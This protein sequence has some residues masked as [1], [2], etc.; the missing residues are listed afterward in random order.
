MFTLVC[1][2]M[3]WW[4][5]A[6]KNHSHVIKTADNVTFFTS[7]FSDIFKIHLQNTFSI[8]ICHHHDIVVLVS[9]TGLLLNQHHA[10]T[11]TNADIIDETCKKHPNDKFEHTEEF[12]HQVQLKL[13]VTSVIPLCFRCVLCCPGLPSLL[14]CL[15]M[16]YWPPRCNAFLT[17]ASCL[18]FSPNSRCLFS[19]RD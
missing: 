8:W 9:C 3:V 17:P 7:D 12:S 16:L 5:Y 2:I 10:I 14:S 1:H 19:L 13:L 6:G 15:L 18:C 11:T 4:D